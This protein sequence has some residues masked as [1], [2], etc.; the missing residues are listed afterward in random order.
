MKFLLMNPPSMGRYFRPATPHVGLG[1]LAEILLTNKHQV[2]I[3]DMRL[4]MKFPELMERIKQF[5]PDY[6]GVTCASLD[7]LKVYDDISQI[8]K[9]FNIKVIMGGPHAS[10]VKEKVL[11]FSK[12]DLVVVG[13]GEQTILEIAKG[14]PY[15]K[16]NGLIFRDKRGNI[17]ENPPRIKIFNLDALPFPK[18]KKFPLHKYLEHKIAI[19]AERGC[20]YNCTYCA[21]RLIL[22][23]GFRAR[24][25]ENIIT[26]IKYWYDKGYKTF[27]FND[28]EFTGWKDWVIKICDLIIKNNIK[29]SFEL[30]TGIRADKT[31]EEMIRKMVQAGFYFF[32]FGAESSDLE[33]LKM[34]RKGITSRQIKRA[35]TLINKLGLESS[36]FFMIG[37]PGD[38]PEKFRKTLQFA[39]SLNLSEVRFYNTIPYPGSD[40]YDWAVKYGRFL[41]PPEIYLSNYDRLQREP[42]W[43]TDTF[44]AQERIKAYDLGE[45]FFAE[46]LYI[47]TFGEN[48]AKPFIFMSK[49]RYIRR[50]LIRLGF[51]FTKLVRKIHKFRAMRKVSK[52]GFAYINPN[53]PAVTN[54]YGR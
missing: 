36:G 9:N 18:Y 26:E 3:V 14:M 25:P 31:D 12:T 33:V 43:E 32:A 20:P 24:T 40:L 51:R 6:I 7:Y 5:R 38:T 23:R 19:M 8:K 41:Y 27:G 30:R 54:P 13:E 37:L 1:Y 35:A 17:I 10:V 53:I 46:R 42:V 52:L 45:Q 49:N 4:G 48:M 50:M 29:A 16:I 2:E 47:K 28:D 44:P 22:G 15:R 34:A 21:S 39:R 11:Q